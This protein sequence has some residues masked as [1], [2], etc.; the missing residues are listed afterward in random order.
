MPQDQRIQQLAAGVTKDTN[1]AV[2]SLMKG[3]STAALDAAGM[4]P[5]GGDA[6]MA[7][8]VAINAVSS[9]NSAV[10]G[11]ATGSGLCTVNM[12]QG[13]VVNAVTSPSM[14]MNAP[15]AIP[16]VGQGYSALLVGRDI[17]NAS[18]EYANCF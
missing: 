18:G 9:V 16:V 4:V 11:D 7:A 6:E 10:Q 5:F 13:A 14:G 8:P 1:C 3:G 12:V 15:R 17:L 2:N